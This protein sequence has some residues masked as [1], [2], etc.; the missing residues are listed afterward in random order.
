MCTLTW[1]LLSKKYYFKKN[2]NLCAEK[3]LTNLKKV[4]TNHGSCL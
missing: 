4:L 1:I 2:N 3:E